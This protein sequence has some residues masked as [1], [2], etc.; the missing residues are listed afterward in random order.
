VKFSRAVV[1]YRV[2]RSVPPNAAELTWLTGSFTMVSRR[3]SGLSR[4][5]LHGTVGGVR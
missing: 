2:L 4:Y 5:R 1:M 3:P